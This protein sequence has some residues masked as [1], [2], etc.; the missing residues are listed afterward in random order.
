VKN[1]NLRRDPVSL[2]ICDVADNFVLSVS[3]GFAEHAG[4]GPLV[5][6]LIANLIGSLDPISDV[7][8]ELLGSCH[9][10]PFFLFRFPLGLGWLGCLRIGIQGYRGWSDCGLG[11]SKQ[12][13]ESDGGGPNL[14]IV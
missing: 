2:V 6:F 12:R 1:G 4:H 14:K 7:D 13:Q 9:G 3:N 10:C 8:L 11:Q 5:P